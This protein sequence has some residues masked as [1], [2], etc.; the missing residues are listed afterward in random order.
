MK[1]GA[2][3]EGA[4]IK[5]LN[6][7]L[8]FRNSSPE[9]IC[10]RDQN[11]H[12]YFTT[13]LGKPYWRKSFYEFQNL[14]TSPKFRKMRDSTQKQAKD[15]LAGVGPLPH[16]FTKYSPL[17]RGEGRGSRREKEARQRHY[18]ASKL[19]D[20]P[21][22]PGLSNGSGTPSA[23]SRGLIPFLAPTPPSE[24]ATLGTS[25][26]QFSLP[27]AVVPHPDPEA[28]EMPE[29]EPKHLIANTGFPQPSLKPLHPVGPFEPR[30]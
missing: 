5:S 26:S 2:T 19:L 3:R 22:Q 17:K 23:Q 8:F 9:H 1:P 27:V 16:L 11:F 28:D 29:L 21:S 24:P 6:F 25:G 13:T 20:L 10:P 7:C 30:I 18:C 15:R 4:L 12:N 14:S